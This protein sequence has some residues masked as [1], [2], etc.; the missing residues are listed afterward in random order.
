MDFDL[1]LAK[2]KQTEPL[3]SSFSNAR[4][5]AF[6][7]SYPYNFGVAVPRLF[8]SFPSYAIYPNAAVEQLVPTG[9]RA[10]LSSG[11][12]EGWTGRESVGTAS[13]HIQDLQLSANSE[14]HFDPAPQFETRYSYAAP[15]QQDWPYETAHYASPN[16]LDLPQ[17]GIVIQTSSN[18]NS[19]YN[20]TAQQD[21]YNQ[22][23]AR[24]NMPNEFDFA[25]QD[26]TVN[27]AHTPF[28]NGFDQVTSTNLLHSGGISEETHFSGNNTFNASNTG[29]NLS[30]NTSHA[31]TSIYNTSSILQDI[32]THA[33][34]PSP[35]PQTSFSSTSASPTSPTPSPTSTR[36]HCPH[37]PSTFARLGD[38]KRHTKIH[39]PER[40][41]RYHCLEPGCE[42]N[43]GK[44]FT[45]RDKWRD[46]VRVVHRV[47]ED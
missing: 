26:N 2:N 23:A 5:L 10:S 1:Q 33:T 45:R 11:V 9:T 42:R 41:R 14:H 46:H 27:T 29:T 25:W 16:E 15:G 44:A 31:S 37:C 39:F 8:V 34:I 21:W 17:A 22:S 32:S 47:T 24:G 6:H 36:H 18:A 30:F 43:G 40:H 19:H 20:T 38:L 4:P 35:S 3:D 7:H 12:H 28:T 13:S